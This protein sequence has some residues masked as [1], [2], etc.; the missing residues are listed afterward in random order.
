M[1]SFE[2]PAINRTNQEIVAGVEAMEAQARITAPS[3][4]PFIHR[5]KCD[6]VELDQMETESRKRD[7]VIEANRIIREVRQ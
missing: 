4:V 7:A 1:S 2:Y 6:I 3:A 5:L